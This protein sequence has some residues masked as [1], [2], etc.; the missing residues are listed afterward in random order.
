MFKLR[1]QK[2]Q[3]LATYPLILSELL[4]FSKA[5]SKARGH[6]TG[7]APVPRFKVVRGR[8][9][10]VQTWSARMTTPLR[11]LTLRVKGQGCICA[12]PLDEAALDK[13]YEKR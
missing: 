7:T 3:T 11:A 4:Q 5:D 10:L 9:T 1:K 2:T 12:V 8:R 6:H 13:I